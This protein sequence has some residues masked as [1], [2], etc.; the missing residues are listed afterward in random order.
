M[1]V[2]LIVSAISVLFVP[3]SAEAC[4]CFTPPD[5]TVP[6]IQAGERI[7]FSVKDGEVTSHVQIQYSGDA[8][9]FGW[10]LPL[11]SVPKLELGTD[12]LF[13]QLY[14]TTQP[15]YKMTVQYDQNCVVNN[16]PGGTGGGSGTGGSGGFSGV[17]AGSA[18]TPLVVQDSIGPYDY[19]VLKADSKDAMLGWLSDNR[20]FVPAGT[21][22]SVTPYIHPGAFFLALKLKSGNSTGDLQPIVLKYTSD[23][24]MIPI[25]LTSTGATENMGVQVWMLGNGRA[26]PRN[27]HH[28][29][30][31]DQ[32]IDWVRSGSNYNAVIIRAVGEAPEKHTFVTEYAGSS[33]V[34]RGKLAPVGRFG[35]Q[36]ELAAQPTALDFV[37]YLYAHGFALPPTM[38]FFGAQVLPG[39]LKAIL[40]KY[41]P[42]PSG[43]TAD[44]F[45][46]NFQ[47]WQSHAVLDYQPI[48]IASEIWSRVVE[49]TQAAS[50]LFDALPTL[51]RLYTTISPADMNKDPAF[52]F[53]PGLPNVA[54]VH[55][56]TMQVSCDSSHYGVE[57]SAELTTEQGS[58]LRFPHGRSGAPEYDINA[59]PASLR[60]EVLR[61]EGPPIVMLDNSQK[62]S[63]PMNPPSTHGCSTAAGAAMLLGLIPGLR[64]L[65][66]RR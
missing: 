39:Q 34:M 52:S 30:I 38:G 54:N 2:F 1:R 36:T 17:D 7:L 16:Y 65:R 37:R 58:H 22:D 41:L 53:N 31:N 45:Y 9:D 48:L 12:E 20:Y 10:L 13:T 63:V 11:P 25:T 21:T 66:R 51:T 5:P 8:K 46:S 26:I 47:Y 60:I 35:L 33:T 29:V 59:V 55:L 14:A 49:P 24:G 18:G 44:Q 4:G 40:A 43:V 6:I 57:S 61:E 3:L 56:A 32:A 19:A 15:Q 42:P 28:T 64:R 62:K 50:A 23:V 27:Y